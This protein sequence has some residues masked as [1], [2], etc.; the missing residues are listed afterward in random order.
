[1][2]IIITILDTT[3]DNTQ[4]ASRPIILHREHITKRL[5]S[6]N[7]YNSLSIREME[8]CMNEEGND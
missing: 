1:M 4:T 2:T 5:N 3:Y 6:N 7:N 8:W